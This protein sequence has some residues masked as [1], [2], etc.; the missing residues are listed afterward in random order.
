M[1]EHYLSELRTVQPHGPYRLAGYC[2]GSIVAFDMAQ[3]LVAEGEQIEL[4]AGFNGP[5]PIWLRTH[6]QPWGQ[7]RPVVAPHR[8]LVRRVAGVL[9]SPKRQWRWSR[10]LAWRFRTRF[11]SWPR[12]RLSLRLGGALPEGIREEYFLNIHAIAELA[13]EPAPYPGSMIVFYGAGLYDDPTLGWK[14][15][16]ASIETVA[17]PGEHAGN[18]TMMAEPYVA[19]VSERLLE[20]LGGSSSFASSTTT[21]A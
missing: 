19:D 10:H 16:A 4:L 15:L 11:V 6:G 3:R 20:L 12:A 18:R 1:S 21:A 8:P 13:Y 9:A 2:F 17:I 7:A 14:G 5:S